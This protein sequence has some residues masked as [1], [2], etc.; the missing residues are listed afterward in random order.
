[1]A[2]AYKAI[3]LNFN[4]IRSLILDNVLEHPILLKAFLEN[5]ITNMT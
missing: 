1:M 3:D 4:F 5:K 2:L